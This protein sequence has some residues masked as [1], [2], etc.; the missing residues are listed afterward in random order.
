MWYFPRGHGHSIQ[1][2]SDGCTFILVFDNGYFSEFG[3]FSITDWLGHTQHEVLAKNFGLPVSA[4]ANFPDH[5]VYIAKG[6]VPP[7]LDEFPAPGTL[8]A[9]P[10][11]HRYRLLAQ[12]PQP[13]PGGEMRIASEVEFPISTT[14]TGA[15]L[16]IAPGGACASCIG[17]R[18]RWSGSTILRAPAA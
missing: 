16:T 10:L 2:L 6:P 18:T 4:F 3:T 13:F 15:L 7:P 9:P 8:N 1:G 14:M 12:A 5:E 11:I 17:I